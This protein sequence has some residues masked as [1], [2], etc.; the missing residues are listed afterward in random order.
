[1]KLETIEPVL[2]KIEFT[3]SINTLHGRLCDADTRIILRNIAS[4][5]FNVNYKMRN[6]AKIA[7]IS[8]ELFLLHARSLRCK[9]STNYIMWYNIDSTA[10]IS[11]VYRIDQLSHLSYSFTSCKLKYHRYNVLNINTRFIDRKTIIQWILQ[12]RRFLLWYTIIIL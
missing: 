5:F 4:Y 1:L 8:Y 12:C 6:V 2:T 9:I 10:V 7:S 11:L 3:N